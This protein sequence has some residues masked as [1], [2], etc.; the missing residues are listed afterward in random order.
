[1][2]ELDFP[3]LINW[4]LYS[5]VYGIFVESDMASILGGI[6]AVVSAPTVEITTLY[7]KV[8]K[9]NTKKKM[10]RIKKLR[11]TPTAAE[12][13]AAPGKRYRGPNDQPPHGSLNIP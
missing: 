5:N 12:R 10:F 13:R 1:M 6:A 4:K 7:N 8:A 3:I 11:A 2:R 9:N